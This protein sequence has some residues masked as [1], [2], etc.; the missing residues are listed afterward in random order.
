MV[1]LSKFP[2]PHGRQ[3]T[4]NRSSSFRLEGMRSVRAHH[5][6]ELEEQFVCVGVTQSRVVPEMSVAILR[7]DLAEF[8]GPIREDTGKAGVRQA[9]VCGAAGAIEA[10]AKSPA[11][12]EAVF[13]VGIHAE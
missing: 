4:R 8:A 12:V 7:T 11:A 5:K 9:G 2:K 1:T 10:A 3:I 13:R 6:K